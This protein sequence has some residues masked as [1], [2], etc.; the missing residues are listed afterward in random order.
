MPFLKPFVQFWCSLRLT[1]VCLIAAMV[2]V[3]VGTLAQVDQGLYD[4][5]KKYFR[6]YFLVPESIGGAGWAQIRLGGSEWQ[7]PAHWNE[8]EPAQFSLINF[9]AQHGDD[10]AVIS[11]TKLAKGTGLLDNVN[12]WRGQLGL[13]G[14]GQDQLAEAT[15]PFEVDGNRGTYVELSGTHDG[16]PTTT[17]GVIHSLSYRSLPEMWF[18][19][20]TGDTEAVMREKEAFREYVRSARYPVMFRFPFVGGYLVGI[21]LLVNLLAAHFQRF[22]FSRK[23]IGIF[24]THAGLILM[25]LGQL[26]TDKYQVES[27]LRLVEGQ[28]KGYSI[29]SSDCELVIIDKSRSDTDTVAAIPA[30]AL[31]QGTTH[32]MG[33]LPFEVTV[34]DFYT[35]SDLVSLGQAEKSRATE[36]KGRELASTPKDSVTS[37]EEVNFPAA[38]LRLKS[39][40]G[41]DLGTWMVAAMFGALTTPIPEQTFEHDGKEYELALRFTRHY[42]PYDIELVDFKHDKFQG[43]EK[44]RNFSSLVIVRERA[45]GAEREVNI[46]MNHPLRTHGKTYFQASFDPKNP[47]ATVL[48]VVRNPG[49]MTPYISCA[50][51]GLGMLIQFLTHLF[52]F[53]KRRKAAA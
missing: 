48:Q 13:G 29:S 24:L 19:K 25:L 50:M 40:D 26:V 27:N 37:L 31:G 7:P 16:R 10:K 32:R 1:V 39:T 53:N 44:A 35:N 49:W 23:K 11:V 15:Q 18:Y 34:L 46:W 4:A 41:A 9:E 36:G 8:T 42:T 3:F 22:T 52:T 38:Y 43:T 12:R 33:T 28:A 17:L 2:L 21:V 47:K 14:I 30:G 20:I 5:Q 45:T 51:V 6:S